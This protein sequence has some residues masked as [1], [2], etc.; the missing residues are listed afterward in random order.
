MKL[1]LQPYFNLISYIGYKDL[2]PYKFILYFPTVLFFIFSL[3]WIYI[4]YKFGDWKNWRVY[5]PTILFFYCGGL[6]Y[7][8]VFHDNLLWSFYSPIFT[9]KFIDFYDMLTIFTATVLVF[10][11]Y[12]PKILHKQFLYTG[13]WIIIYSAIE[14]LFVALGGIIYANG[15][16][17]AWSIVH[18]GYQ[19][20]LLIIHHKK[21]LLAW[22]LAFITLIIV[23][24]LLKAP[25]N[26][27]K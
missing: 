8:V 12:F 18:N 9:H 19:F 5:Y 24:S 6:I 4:A 3:V 7:N 17:I 15:W 13:M 14:L 25:I 23:S 11:P 27:I 26:I 1:M 10:I 16:T 21:P 22:C 20:P 2:F